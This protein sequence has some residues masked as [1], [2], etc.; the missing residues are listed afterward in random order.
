MTSVAP[1][2]LEIR[3]VRNHTSEIFD[4]ARYGSVDEMLGLLVAGQ[5]SLTDCDE[6]GHSLLGVDDTP[7]ED[8]DQPS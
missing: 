5:G 7:F 6:D 2:T 4:V 1:A 8:N 3:N